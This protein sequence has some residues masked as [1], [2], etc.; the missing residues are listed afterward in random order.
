MLLIAF[1]Y[2]P[3]YT[4][5]ALSVFFPQS[6]KKD[7]SN[8]TMKNDITDGINKQTNLPLYSSNSFFYSMTNHVNKT[9]KFLSINPKELVN[10]ID[11]ALPFEQQSV[12]NSYIG[13]EVN[14]KLKY[15]Y[16]QENENGTYIVSTYYLKAIPSVS[17]DVDISKF[18]FL[19]TISV[20]TSITVNGVI[21]GF[22]GTI[23][24]ELQD[25]FIVL[26]K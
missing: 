3:Q 23:G 2:L 25:V 1:R 5:K 14:W 9:G 12:I 4:N 10:T 8:S 18:P 16:I 22:L 11:A 20:G 19:K 7:T 13:S 6:Q 26:D 17:F 24:I 21:S 15:E